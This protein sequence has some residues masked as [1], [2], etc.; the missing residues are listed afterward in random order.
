MRGPL[1]TAPPRTESDASS[2]GLAPCAST[3][4]PRAAL[5]RRCKKSRAV[6]PSARARYRP[7]S[8]APPRY[9]TCTDEYVIMSS[10]P[11]GGTLQLGS[12]GDLQAS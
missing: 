3:V 9:I 8:P 11:A 4:R 2:S 10:A 12:S 1:G 7:G 6:T 5:L